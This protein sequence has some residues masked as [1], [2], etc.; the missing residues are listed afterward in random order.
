MLA[1]LGSEEEN[2]VMAVVLRSSLEGDDVAL[3]PLS[4]KKSAAVSD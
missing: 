2:T 3:K 4:H 1:V